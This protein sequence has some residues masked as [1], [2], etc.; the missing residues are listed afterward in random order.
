MPDIIINYNDESLSSPRASRASMVMSVHLVLG[1]VFG[2]L[3]DMLN[4]PEGSGGH[5]G[6]SI[7]A[8]GMGLRCL[9]STTSSGDVLAKLLDE[10]GTK[11]RNPPYRGTQRTDDHHEDVC[12]GHGDDY[13]FGGHMW[14]PRSRDIRLVWLILAVHHARQAR[15]RHFPNVTMLSPKYE[16]HRDV[17]PGRADH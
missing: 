14:G 16:I 17:E 8:I 5:P 2:R 4:D 1:V 11:S 6:H 13:S 10:P 15:F 9:P 7:S 3:Q 12:G